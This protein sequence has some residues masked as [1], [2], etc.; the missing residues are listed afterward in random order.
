ME[1]SLEIVFHQLEPSAAVEAAIRERFAKLE[2]R[3]DRVTACRVSSRPCTGSIH[4]Q[5]VR[6]PHRPARAGSRARGQ[7]TAAEGQG[8]LGQPRRLHLDPRRVRRR[9]AAAEALQA[10]AARGCPAA[11]AA[12]PGPGGRDAPAGLGLSARPAR[13]LL[14]FHRNAVLDGSF[15]ALAMGDVVHYVAVTAEPVRP[16]Q[17]LEGFGSRPRPCLGNRLATASA[18][19]RIYA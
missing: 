2:K 1:E 18:P 19:E 7:Q 5:R 3:Y 4:G 8:A 12:V 15:D 13:A 10:A 14:Y 17:G 11:G 16:R 6:G 9:R